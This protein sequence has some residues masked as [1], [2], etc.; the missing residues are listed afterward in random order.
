LKNY[1][2]EFDEKYVWD[3]FRHFVASQNQF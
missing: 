3:W 2:I 1:E